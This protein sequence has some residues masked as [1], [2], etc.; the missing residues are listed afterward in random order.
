[1]ALLIHV[2]KA[3][4]MKSQIITPGWQKVEVE[5]VYSKMSKD[6]QSTNYWAVLLF[7]DDPDGRTLEH[8]FNSK[9][10]GISLQNFCAA[11][12]GKTV[13]DFMAGMPKA[14]DI[15]LESTVGK[16]L[17]VKVVNTIF[18]GRPVNKVEDFCPI[19]KVPF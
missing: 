5:S 11:V 8:N 13:V 14:I 6:G 18:D 4:L 10:L 3:D 1:M 12:A 15:D 19:D 16:K 7:T 9:A 2:T 17:M